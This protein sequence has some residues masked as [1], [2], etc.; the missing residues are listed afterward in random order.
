MLGVILIL[1]TGTAAGTGS[2]VGRRGRCPNVVTWRM[3]DGVVDMTASD[4]RSAEVIQTQARI[5][6]ISLA[7][8]FYCRTRGAMPTTSGALI[9]AS[10]SIPEEFKSCRIS[11]SFF[12][13]AWGH[14]IYV[15]LRSGP[16]G[17]VVSS[18]GADGVFATADDI[19]TPS[20]A[21]SH[22]E[23]ASFEQYCRQGK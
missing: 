7:T 3:P 8:V 1:V 14:P 10:K 9:E 12:E 21:M 4:T 15:S 18:A 2:P 11:D 19:P 5:N 13:D 17:F 23:A 6:L 20:K 22:T 16:G